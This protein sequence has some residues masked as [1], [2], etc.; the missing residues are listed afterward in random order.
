MFVFM[1]LGYEFL[2]TT[3]KLEKP[4]FPSIHPPKPVER[5]ALHSLAHRIIPTYTRRPRSRAPVV[6]SSYIGWGAYF[7]LISLATFYYIQ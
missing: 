1:S 4:R 7:S 3:I 6:F 2:T 5:I